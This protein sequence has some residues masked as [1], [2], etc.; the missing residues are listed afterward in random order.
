MSKISRI[1]LFFDLKNIKLGEELLLVTL[2]E[3]HYFSKL[4]PIFDMIKAIQINFDK[5]MIDVN[6]IY[7]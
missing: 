7:Q 5:K 3:A 1:C 6:R 4:C 2:F